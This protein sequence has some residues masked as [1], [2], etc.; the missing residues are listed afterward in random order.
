MREVAIVYYRG[1]IAYD[2]DGYGTE[3]MVAASITDWTSVTDD[4]FKLL[5]Q[6][7]TKK[8]F[9][10]IEKPKDQSSIIRKT[11]MDELAEIEKEKKKKE[12]E[13][14]L[15]E[16][17]AAQRRAKKLAKDMVARKALYQELRK[18]FEN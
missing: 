17:A 8:R 12:E 18:E 11:V 14:R 6:A 16:E 13:T 1:G 5:L 3:L 9:N 10:L 4:E 15:K 7:A 2:Y